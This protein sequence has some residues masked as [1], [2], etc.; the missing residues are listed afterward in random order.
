[1]SEQ[2][3]AVSPIDGRYRSSTEKLQEYC[4]EFGLIRYRLICMSVYLLLLV[5]ENVV[6]IA[7]TPN[8]L[9]KLTA[10][11]D[12]FT[13]EDAVIVQKIERKGHGK[14]PATN[15]DVKACEL[16]LRDKLIDAGFEELVEWVHFGCTSED[17]N[18]AAY[19]FMLSDVLNEVIFTELNELDDEL[20]KRAE[21]YSQI[22]MLARTHGQPASP[23][24]LGKEFNV[25]RRRLR[26]Q[27]DQ[28]DEHRILVKLNGASGNF[29]AGAFA[30]PRTD[31]LTVSNRFVDALNVK[32]AGTFHLNDV[33]TQ[34]EP[35]DTYAELFAILMRINVIL[36]GFCQDIWRYISDDL[37]AQTP[38]E[39]E[40]GSSAMP[41][42]VNP[43]NFE[44]AEGNLGMANAF[45]EHF[46][47]KLPISRLQR[48][49]SDSTVERNFGSAF[50]HCVIAYENIKKGLKKIN[51]NEAA[52]RAA[53]DAHPEVLSEAYQTLLRSI[54]YPEGYNALK[55][56]TRGKKVTLEMMHDFVRSLDDEKVS[57]DVKEKM[58]ALRPE[59]YI[60][61]APELARL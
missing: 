14:H 26:R 57:S 39:G 15:H 41:Q 3:M 46:N 17:V 18:N 7:F 1:M 53:L 54:G 45:F 42:K 49:L 31:W 38:V 24:T 21:S 20:V 10:L 50:A 28:L 9:D 29:C 52:I 56:L 34:I 60:G 5:R 48:D 59:T 37:L 61:L 13:L 32:A 25:F 36:T 6:P 12:D 23:T 58:L 8:S 4:S 43:I 44:N 27:M 11:L 22:A 35:H 19:A 2:L 30:L 55:E 40:V 16:F 47:R 51:P 33:T